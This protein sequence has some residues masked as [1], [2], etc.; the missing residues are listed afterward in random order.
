MSRKDHTG[1]APEYFIRFRAERVNRSQRQ[2]KDHHEHNGV[3]GDSL[4]ILLAKQPV[5]ER[6]D[7]LHLWIKG[8]CC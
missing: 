1:Y 5:D 2:G 3:L 8:L 4:T 7:S 6:R